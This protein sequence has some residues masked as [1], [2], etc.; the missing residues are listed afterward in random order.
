MGEGEGVYALCE[1]RTACAA[2]PDGKTMLFLEYAEMTKE[3]TIVE[4]KGMS[5]KLPNDFFNGET[6]GYR[7]PEETL[8]SPGIPA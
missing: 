8:N 5:L 4:I 1:D 6:R 3:A 2:L 7:T